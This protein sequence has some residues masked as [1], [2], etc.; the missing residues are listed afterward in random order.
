WLV[1]S[2]LDTRKVVVVDPGDAAPV[3]RMLREREWS[4]AGI[5]VT[6]HHADH[7]GGV[8]QL[9]A[10]YAVRVY[11]PAGEDIPGEAQGL[12]EGDQ[13][14]LPDLGLQFSVLD[15]PG[16]T[17]G[18]IAYLG[19]GALFCGDTL[20]SAG[21]GRLFEGTAEQMHASLAKL[22]ALDSNTLVYCGH[23][24]TV[25]NLRFALAVEPQNPAVANYYEECRVKRDRDQATLPSNIDL[26]RSVNPFFR[27]NTETVKR[28]AEVH[29]GHALDST[30]AVFA[31]VRA[32]KD[33]FRATP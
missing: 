29:A 30:V 13:V 7:V 1:H 28:A 8:A 18:H 16:H 24:Y 32:W 22:A 15:V 17:A 21:C 27:C 33:G 4:L 20:F 31:A 12:S 19:H 11:G 25:A 3:Q 14:P 23:E 2:P 26:E 6:H 10:E 9:A 5:L